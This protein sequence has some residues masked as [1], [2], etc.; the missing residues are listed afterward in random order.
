SANIYFVFLAALNW[1]PQI[2]VFHKEITMVPL[3]IVL[4]VIAIKDAV[5]DYKRYCVDRRINFT[6]TSVYN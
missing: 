4:G 6:K 3:V 1:V 2:G 5:E